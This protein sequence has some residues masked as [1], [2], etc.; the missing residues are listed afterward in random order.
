MREPIRDDLQII[1]TLKMN[2]IIKFGL[3]ATVLAAFAFV[4]CQKDDEEIVNGDNN[5]IPVDTVTT[6]DTVNHAEELINEFFPRGIFSKISPADKST[7]VAVHY[8]PQVDFRVPINTDIEFSVNKQGTFRLSIAE[9]TII[10]ADDGTKMD[11]DYTL[12]NDNRTCVFNI[13]ELYES[14]AS[15]TVNVKVRFEKKESGVWQTI[16]DNNGN[17]YLKEITT[18]FTADNKPLSFTSENILYS[19]PADRQRNFLP[20][21]TN[22]AYMILEFDYTYVF[23]EC[24]AKGYEQKIR[25]TPFGGETTTVDFTYT[26]ATNGCGR[27]EIDYSVADLHLENNVIYHL[28]IVNIAKDSSQIDASVPYEICAIDFRTSSYNTFAE[29][30]DN[31]S[32]SESD[33]AIQ[34]TGT[35]YQLVWNF[36][37]LSEVVES[38]D[39]CDYNY[40]Q[41]TNCLL[42]LNLDY[43]NCQW[44][45]EKIAPLIYEN[46]DVLSIAGNY[47]PPTTN[48]YTIGAADDYLLSDEE[49]ETG[50]FAK[51]KGTGAFACNA[52]KY[53]NIDYREITK[54]LLNAEERNKGAEELINTDY[55]PNLIEG[56]Y[57]MKIEYTLPGK[58]IVT[59]KYVCDLKYTY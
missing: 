12:S 22:L 23:D 59:S 16:K 24:K 13:K 48:V 34:V 52:S 50:V 32:Y 26:T 15:Y 35:V 5:Q 39:L 4:G 30:M 10:K 42:R 53:I 20:K 29:K 31:I 14:G 3:I 56:N 9:F 47:T 27:C 36:E 33:M 55:L 44:Y 7:S 1:K 17:D 46:D 19:Y 54:K 21:E 38:F 28:A 40:D 58:N 11:G 41:Q 37:D 45:K 51:H 2:K 25:I 57:P 49:V 6:I 43:D 18:Q 8:K